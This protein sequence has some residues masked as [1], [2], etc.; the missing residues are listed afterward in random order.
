MEYPGMAD[1]F[2]KL[3]KEY[4]D[5]LNQRS[6]QWSNLGKVLSNTPNNKQ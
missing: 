2:K 1:N 4:T 5:G 3:I 6:M